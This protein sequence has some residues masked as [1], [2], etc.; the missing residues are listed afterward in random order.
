MVFQ[1]KYAA[2]LNLI[3]PWPKIF[4]ALLLQV[5]AS[6]VGT[7]SP[8]QAGK[9]PRTGMLIIVPLSGA[10]AVGFGRLAQQE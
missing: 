8:M 1:P 2:Y 9:P 7:R 5:S 4:I 10:S 3:E 6:T